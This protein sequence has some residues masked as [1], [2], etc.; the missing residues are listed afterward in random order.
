[1][2]NSNHDDGTSNGRSDYSISWWNRARFRWI[3]SR[4]D[5]RRC[6][7]FWKPV[8]KCNILLNR[9][10]QAIMFG[11]PERTTKA[12]SQLWSESRTM[13]WFRL[14]WRHCTALLAS[15]LGYRLSVNH[16]IAVDGKKIVRLRIEDQKRWCDILIL[17]CAHVVN[18][19]SS[20]WLLGGRPQ[21][22]PQTWLPMGQPNVSTGTD[23]CEGTFK[24]NKHGNLCRS[25]TSALITMCHF[26]RGHK[27][28]RQQ[29]KQDYSTV[30][31][32]C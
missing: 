15:A 9:P 25:P 20:I 30:H 31:V 10:R 26:G 8:M 18:L 6:G 24:S 4:C 11:L 16:T 1:M 5:S 17:R 13:S 28:I 27:K 21:P 32:G 3:W 23:Q 19:A 22:Q 2:H 29:S 7:W 14:R 12:S